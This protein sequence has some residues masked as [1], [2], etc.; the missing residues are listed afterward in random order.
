MRNVAFSLVFALSLPALADEPSLARTFRWTS[1]SRAK[2]EIRCSSHDGQD[3][4]QHRHSGGAGIA[5]LGYWVVG[6]SQHL[7]VY[8]QE[9]IQSRAAWNRQAGSS[10]D[11]LTGV[12]EETYS[13]LVPVGQSPA[14]PGFGSRSLFAAEVSLKTFKVTR[15]GEVI[16]GETVRLRDFTGAPKKVLCEI[17]E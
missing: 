4:R 17:Q 10:S 8:T 13:N 15:E 7:L 14:L 12:I 1:E 6:G 11:E 3:N 9:D 5:A 2:I 16:E